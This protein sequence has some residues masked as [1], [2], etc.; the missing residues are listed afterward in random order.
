MPLVTHFECSSPG[1]STIKRKS[2]LG[3]KKFC[4][5][6]FFAQYGIYCSNRL[7]NWT[8]RVCQP[9]RPIFYILGE[10]CPVNLSYSSGLLYAAVYK[11]QFE[12]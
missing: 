2:V 12:S 9:I 11:A 8:Q 6:F 7:A 1:N 10:K 4:R 3:T 5:T